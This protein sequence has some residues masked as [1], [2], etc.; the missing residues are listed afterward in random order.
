M[1]DLIS[2]IVP[3]YN[4]EKYLVDSLD[5]VINQTYENLEIILVDDG[6]TDRSLDKRV[7][8]L[9]RKNGGI[10]MAMRLGVA[11]ANGKYIARHDGDD[12]NRLD[13]YEKQLEYLKNNN[14]DLIG[15]YLKGFGDGDREYMKLMET[16][17]IPIKNYMDQ[18]NRAYFGR[19]PNGG[20]IF[21]KSYLFKTINPFQHRYGCVEDRLIFLEFHTK[22][23][24]I[25]VIEEELYYYRV[26]GNNSSIV[27]GTGIKIAFLHLELLF[28][29]LF[30]TYIEKSKHVIV[31]QSSD[32][33]E[34]VKNIL[35]EHEN[36]IYVDENM[37]EEFMIREIYNFDS[38]ET[39]FFIGTVFF[40]SAREFLKNFGYHHLKNLFWIV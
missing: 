36:I 30:K 3:V 24:R 38:E 14:Y 18:F 11:V 25:G 9:T 33:I 26:H 10:C 32:K 13:R 2:V 21:G 27:D 8:V 31:I 16:L 34:L 12:I 39:T 6:S 15:C 5:S 23:H 29:Y 20:A 1:E 22:G 7:K 37:I 40:E 4:V 19:Y 17:N 28:K 35:N